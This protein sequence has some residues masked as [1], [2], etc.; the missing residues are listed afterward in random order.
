MIMKQIV[1]K[2]CDV[3]VVGAGL[4]GLRAGITALSHSRDLNVR[5]A[6][7]GRGPSGSSFTNPNHALGIM[8]C[9]TSQEKEVFIE[10][11][12]AIA[13]PGLIIP[14]LVDVLA[15]ESG[16]VYH[17]LVQTGLDFKQDNIGENRRF[18]ACFLQQPPMAS[19]FGG[20]SSAFFLL[21][22]RFHDAGGKAWEGLSLLD[23]VTNDENRVIGA[24]FE[25]KA[26]GQIRAVHCQALIMA[27]GGCAGLFSRSLTDPGNTGAPLALMHRE[28]ARLINMNYL[29][30]IWYR[31]N[32]WE[33][34]FCTSLGRPGAA[35][36]SPDGQRVEIPEGVRD[37]LAARGAHV[38][39]AHG[40]EDSVVDA[41]LCGHGDAKGVVR[42]MSG[43]DEG[44]D[45]ALYAHAQNGGVLIDAMSRTGVPG[46]FTC[47]ECA[48]GMHGA[49]RVG[50]AMV[51][52]SQVFGAR[53]GLSAARFAHDPW[54]ESQRTFMDRVSSLS[55]LDG[56]DT[57][58][59]K[60]GLDH[61][62][63]ILEGNEGPFPRP[64]REQRLEAV[65][66][67]HSQARDFRLKNALACARMMLA[68][69]GPSCG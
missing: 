60:N 45:V 47:G 11:A 40:R 38:P 3:L 65:T 19:V 61:L 13:G 4:A 10:T 34:W 29:Q 20:L 43:G 27:T 37:R 25:E 32:P 16:F 30:Y 55:C 57:V 33:P 58:E 17:D 51:L 35:V 26:T 41:F 6:S 44:I 52:S 39:V 22:R 21:S 12:M 49:N 14:E 46:L 7:L 64:G 23:L 56:D 28:G 36:R 9:R 1:Y 24:L 69:G 8:V 50:G 18:P 2:S 67:M 31:H 62:K 42:V 54:Q 66:L 48:G 53:A 15:E 59:R 5:I 63:T 68:S